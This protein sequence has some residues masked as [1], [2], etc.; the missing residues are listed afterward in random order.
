MIIESFLD[1]DLEYWLHYSQYI[2][3]SL[4]INKIITVI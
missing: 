3:Y 2:I 1:D 4:N